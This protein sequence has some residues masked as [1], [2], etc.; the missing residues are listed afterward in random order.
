MAGVNALIRA[1]LASTWLLINQISAHII[2]AGGKRL[3]PC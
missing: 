3:R 2:A 1:R